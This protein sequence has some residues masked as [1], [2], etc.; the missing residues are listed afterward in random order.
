MQR[1]MT[2]SEKIITH[3]ELATSEAP[4]STLHCGDVCG[5]HGLWERRK[6]T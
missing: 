4:V 6:P 1:R 2:L 5:I 3:V